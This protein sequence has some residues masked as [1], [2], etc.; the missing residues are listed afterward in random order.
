VGGS[1][2]GYSQGYRAQDYIVIER[3]EQP[4]GEKEKVVFLNNAAQ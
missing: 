3:F 1:F 2:T 4:D